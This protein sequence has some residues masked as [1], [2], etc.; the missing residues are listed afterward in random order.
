MPK[1]G[2]EA[3]WMVGT[4]YKKG[5]IFQIFSNIFMQTK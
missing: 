5:N 2:R 3:S 1:E 4:A